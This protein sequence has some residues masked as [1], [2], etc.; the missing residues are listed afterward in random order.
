MADAGRP[1]SACKLPSPCLAKLVGSPMCG[2]SQAGWPRHCLLL[3]L[4]EP[5]TN[6]APGHAP[7]PLQLQGGVRGGRNLMRMRGEGV[8]R[9][10]KERPWWGINSRFCNGE[11][12]FL[13]V[14]KKNARLVK[15]FAVWSS[16]AC[17]VAKFPLLQFVHR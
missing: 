17:L 11:K 5:S 9:L 15:P 3:L 10:V 8:Q 6:P 14:G 2:F 16:S 12:E 7:F 13:N 1:T 4:P